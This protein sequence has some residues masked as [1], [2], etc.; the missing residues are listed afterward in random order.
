MSADLKTA[1]IISWVVIAWTILM[2]VLAAGGVDIPPGV[3]M[4]ALLGVVGGIVVLRN[5]RGLSR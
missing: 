5:K 4:A 2:L 1:T 3:A